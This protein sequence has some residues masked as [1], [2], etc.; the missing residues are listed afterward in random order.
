MSG[1]SRWLDVQKRFVDLGMPDPDSDW[2]PEFR[3][4]MQT[5]YAEALEEGKLTSDM[6]QY[7][8]WAFR[9]LRSGKVP[10]LFMRASDDPGSYG[11]TYSVG[12]LKD[13]AVGYV[14]AAE[15]QTVI[16]LD[17]VETIARAYDV[18]PKTVEKWV[19]ESPGI[20]PMSDPMQ[21]GEKAAAAWGR[22]YRLTAGRKK[23]TKVRS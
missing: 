3:S 6:S 5:A 15:V 2:P 11:D 18:H 12:M 13:W 1:Y 10:E 14:R 17:P 9:E 23:P 8:A 22:R 19:R 16:D 4:E 21:V 7:L 20:S